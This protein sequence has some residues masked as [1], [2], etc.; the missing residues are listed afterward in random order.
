[1]PGTVLGPGDL[2]IK[3]NRT[4]DLLELPFL[5]EGTLSPA[6]FGFVDQ[7]SR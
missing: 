7:N 3:K 1:M 2:M 5:V 6:S 4:L